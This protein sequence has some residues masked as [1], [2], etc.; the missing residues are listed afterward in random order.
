MK[1]N[2]TLHFD[3]QN[4]KQLY[5]LLI[6]EDYDFKGKEIEVKINQF[7]SYVEVIVIASTPQ[8]LKIGTTAVINSCDVIY[9]TINVVN[10]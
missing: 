1:S 7:D 6:T 4:P 8:L 3:F 2:A 5:D 9:K 10:N